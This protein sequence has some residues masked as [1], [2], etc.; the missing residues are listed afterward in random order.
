[1]AKTNFT[2]VEEALAEG[3]R[4]IEV[5]KLLD[6]ADENA[7]A[8][9]KKSK[10]SKTPPAPKVDAIH[11]HRLNMINN[12]LKTLEKIGKTPYQNLRIDKDEIKRFLKDPTVLT[13]EDWEKVALMKEQIAAYKVELEKNPDEKEK[14]DDDLIN[15]QRKSQITKRFNINKKWI[16]LK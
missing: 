3:M 14:N 12:E 16:P 10:S 7:V 9:N 2:K 4:K 5:N 15:Q 8:N 13:A 1:M 11:M 6:I